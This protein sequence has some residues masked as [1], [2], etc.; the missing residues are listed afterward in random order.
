MPGEGLS[1]IEK[2]IV[3][4]APRARVWRALADVAEFASW[5]RVKAE[6]EFKTGARL[7]M[8]STYPG[9][10]GEAFYVEV[11]EVEPE[12]R[13][14][15]RWDPGGEQ[16]GSPGADD[17]QTRVVFELEDVE[18]GT[19]VKVTESGFDRLTLA[20]RAKAFE[21]NSEGW[22]LQLQAIRTYVDEAA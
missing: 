19:R 12:R 3:V 15:W 17:V 6:G 22:E 5:F 14:S 2:E 10:E 20:R 13:L 21:D 9:H 8:V 7:E 11:D 4:R 16:T 18:G 1:R